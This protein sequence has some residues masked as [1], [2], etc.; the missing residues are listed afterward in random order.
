M[1]KYVYSTPPP[2]RE[3]AEVIE[4]FGMTP[5]RAAIL[6]HLWQS[7]DGATS[8]DIGRYLKVNY[9]TVARHLVRLEE[10]GAVESDADIDRQGVRVIY[11]VSADGF[12]SAVTE[13]LQY[14][15]GR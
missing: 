12:D 14:L 5:L 2:P 13:L 10:L 8:G 4:I 3:A 15:K 11:K 1:P 7:P 9:R 6:R